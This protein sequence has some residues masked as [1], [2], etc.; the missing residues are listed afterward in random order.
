MLL[1]VVLAAAHAPV[2]PV[3]AA[4][5]RGEWKRDALAA[6]IVMI[7]CLV[8]WVIQEWDLRRSTSALGWLGLLL[9]VVVSFGSA[10]LI[11]APFGSSKEKLTWKSCSGALRPRPRCTSPG[12]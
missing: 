7:I 12:A 2:W 11:A 4:A 9:M 5:F 3:D 10:M 6:G 8:A 1:P